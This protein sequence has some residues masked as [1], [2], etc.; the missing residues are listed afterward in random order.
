VVVPGE[1]LVIV[2]G[3]YARASAVRGCR[4][5]DLRRA[6]FFSSSG[7]KDPRGA[8]TSDEELVELEHGFDHERAREHDHVED[9]TRGR[10]RARA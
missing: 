7:L 1:T 10:R 6:S 2:G 5:R 8:P 9:R 3:F 4:S